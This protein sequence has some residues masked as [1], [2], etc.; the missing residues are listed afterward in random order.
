MTS[1]GDWLRLQEIKLSASATLDAISYRWRYDMRY[2]R[3]VIDRYYRQRP[4]VLHL[5]VQFALLWL[6]L[7]GIST[8]EGW[9]IDK[10]TMVWWILGGAVSIPLLSSITKQGIVLKYRRRESFGTEASCSMTEAGVAIHQASLN[11]TYPWSVY[12]RAVRFPDGLLLLGTGSIRWLPDE[13]LS[14]GTASAATTLV[15]SHIPM[16][17]FN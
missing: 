7:L 9:G 6:L 2:Y 3:A 1:Q 10:G 4:W 17:R 15:E 11:G 16:R 12:S 5:W 13:S 14:E 8:A